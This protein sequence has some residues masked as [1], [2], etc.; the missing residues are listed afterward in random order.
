MR[1]IQNYQLFLFDFD[2]LLVNTEEIHYLAYKRMLAGRGFNL[3]WDFNRYCRAAHYQS[4]AVKEQIYEEYPALKAMEPDWNVLYLEK[5]AAV[6]SLLNE[7]AVHLMP[8][9]ERLLNRLQEANV[10]RCVVTHS[11]QEL[12][13]VVL[14]KNPILKTI[15]YWVTREDYS[16]PKPNPEC[17]L[18]A[19]E[20]YALKTDKV[21]G[22]EDTPRGLTALLATRAKPVLIC[23]AD[24]PEIPS[25]LKQGAQHFRSLEDLAF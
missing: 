18:K 10:K 15:P 20:K 16:S 2:G 7:G 1:W 12:I 13:N 6:V 14:K 11:P 4:E 22:F 25:F 23:Q 17:F 21:I 9:V 8:G 5:K 19:I 24:Y 3:D